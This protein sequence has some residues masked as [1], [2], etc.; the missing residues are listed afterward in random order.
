MQGSAQPL[1]VRHSARNLTDG[2]GLVLVRK[3]F[4]R[5][6]LAG[7]IDCRTGKEKGFF[8]PSL[9]VEVWVVLL[10]YG[11]GVM[12]EPASPAPASGGRSPIACAAPSALPPP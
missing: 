8:R 7:W 12:D 11:G 1:R 9:M 4:D 2:G 10:L 3:L 5:L 6:G